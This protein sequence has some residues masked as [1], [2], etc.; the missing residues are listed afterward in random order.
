MEVVR[1]GG[2]GGELGAPSDESFSAGLEFWC[3][4]VGRLGVGSVGLGVF[5]RE[6]C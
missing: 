3:E 6:W 1:G 5:F 4:W 2:S